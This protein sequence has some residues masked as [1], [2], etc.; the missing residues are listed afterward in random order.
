M[1][2]PD[3]GLCENANTPDGDRL[4]TS[5]SSD[6]VDLASSRY[7]RYSSLVMSWAAEELTLLKK[8]WSSGQSAAQIA[9]R[10]GYSRN[11]V[12]AKLT[13]LGLKRGHRPPTAKPLIVSAPKRRQ[14]VLE[15][16]AHPTA[17]VV[18]SRKPV[19]RQPQEFSKKT[20]YEM[21]AEAVRNT[22]PS[23]SGSQQGPRC[24]TRS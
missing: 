5:V 7:S 6:D 18:S 12:C 9:S 14:R 8:L 10:L 23:K 13:R 15:A 1:S 22:H 19:V 3:L 24:R 21:L 17:K 20:L 4:W 16:C 2:A 11:A